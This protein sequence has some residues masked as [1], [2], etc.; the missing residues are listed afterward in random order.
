MIVAAQRI[1][2]DHIRAKLH[3]QDRI[4]ADMTQQLAIDEI[5]Q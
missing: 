1:D 4:V 2:R 3:Q 5:L